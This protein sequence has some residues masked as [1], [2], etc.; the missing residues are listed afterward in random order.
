[1]ALVNWLSVLILV[2]GFSN[3]ELF[4]SNAHLQTALYAERDIANLLQSY[5]EQEEA[6]LE[7][8]RQ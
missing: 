7:K 6:R 5:V 3:G 8:I 4:T 2:I 1:M